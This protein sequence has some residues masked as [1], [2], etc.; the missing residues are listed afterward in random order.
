ME[1]SELFSEMPYSPEM[2]SPPAVTEDGF[3]ERCLMRVA[4]RTVGSL[5]AMR[6]AFESALSG[7]GVQA[8]IVSDYDL[9]GLT[10]LVEA[11]GVVLNI[12]E[13]PDESP[14]TP[15]ACAEIISGL[16]TAPVLI[17]SDSVWVAEYRSG[18]QHRFEVILSNLL[19]NP[20]RTAWWANSALLGMARLDEEGYLRG[21]A[22]NPHPVDY[23]AR[24]TP[25][26]VLSLYLP[27]IGHAK[28]WASRRWLSRNLMRILLRLQH[29]SRR[30]DAPDDHAC[31]ATSDF[32]SVMKYVDRPGTPWIQ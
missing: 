10:E 26:S 9:F 24:T 7:R 19:A 15:Q 28:H 8:A 6:T 17:V 21:P 4:R 11:A 13:S 2:L 14:W 29:D 31:F 16:S 12:G 3:V 22:R 30:F 18:T 32:F 20:A 23:E 25:W 27:P 5:P 1:D